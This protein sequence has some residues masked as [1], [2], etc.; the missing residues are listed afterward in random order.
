MHF[1]ITRG[2]G[3]IFCGSVATVHIN[4][5][6]SFQ[7]KILYLDLVDLRTKEDRK[8]GKGFTGKRHFGFK[9]EKY[10]TGSMTSPHY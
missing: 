5:H 1:T 7:D 4:Q 10:Q 3:F 6:P 8:T 2:C 9:S